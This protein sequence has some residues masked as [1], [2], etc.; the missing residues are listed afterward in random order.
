MVGVNPQTFSVQ[1][2]QNYYFV[3]RL[4]SGILDSLVL[5]VDS[6]FIFVC[7]LNW[8]LWNWESAGHQISNKGQW[9]LHCLT[10]GSFSGQ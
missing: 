2:D 4:I 6:V 5:V 8:Q 9:M 3:I 1:T 10:D 7:L